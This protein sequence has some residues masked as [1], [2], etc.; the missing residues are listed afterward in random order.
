MIGDTIMDL[1]SANSAQISS[2]GLLCGYGKK[3][4]SITRIFQRGGQ[5]KPA[6]GS[7]VGCVSRSGGYLH[8]NQR[9]RNGSLSD[10]RSCYVKSGHIADK[11]NYSQEC[12]HT[13]LYHNYCQSRYRTAI[14]PPSLCAFPERCFRNLHSAYYGQLYYFG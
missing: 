13:L 12:A 4:T 7:H 14:S 10:F 3:E 2:I 8:C 9:F 6:F 1:Q 11:G 5:R